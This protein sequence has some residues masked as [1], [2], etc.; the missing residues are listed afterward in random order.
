MNL[1]Y[2]VKAVSADK[3][4]NKINGGNSMLTDCMAIAN[5]ALK[6][7]YAIGIAIT[8]SGP[9]GYFN[10]W[11]K[12]DAVG[13]SYGPNIKGVVVA[14]DYWTAA[15]HE[16]GHTYNLYW[17]TPE[18][19]SQ[20]PLYGQMASGVCAASGNWRSGQ[21]FMGCAPYK[22]LDNTWVNSQGTYNPLFAKLTQT[23]TDPEIVVVS[24][25][26]HSGGSPD[27]PSF[28]TPFTWSKLQ[29]IPSEIVSGDY[30]LKFLDSAN[31]EIQGTEVMF[32]AQTRASISVGV[33][34]GKDRPEAGSGTIVS[35][36]A[37]F[38]FATV[39]PA[40]T[41]EVQVLDTT[42]PADQQVKGTIMESQIVDVGP[43]TVETEIG[44]SGLNGWFVSNVGVSLAATAAE[45]IGVKEIHYAL[46]GG[47][48]TVVQGNT[49][50]FTISTDGTHSLAYF[51]VD[52]NE[53]AENPQTKTIKIDKTVPT[54]T[55]SLPSTVLLKQVISAT[56]TATDSTSGVDPSSG[57]LPIDT[58]SVGTKTI[59]VTVWDK[60]GNAKTVTKTVNVE[61]NFIGF[62]DPINNDGTSI[63]K[64]KSTVPVK[65]Q[66]KDAQG[67]YVSTAVASISVAKLSNN[68]WG[69]DMEPVSTASSTQGTIF[70]YD[71]SSNQYIFNLSTKELSTG[72]WRIS[73]LLGDG[74]VKTVIISLR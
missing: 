59:S 53:I 36:D 73:S 64:L 14:Q 35:D 57:T 56:W 4:Q 10:K 32:D 50:S 38:C 61:Y 3:G 7:N 49:A 17:E 28:E 39:L 37:G 6:K 25:I 18:E 62:L 26:F 63:F 74:T 44:T 60:A 24:G 30:A 9:L 72:S 2:P 21:D 12:P 67:N 54:V 66:L 42:L 40:G 33:T 20:Y 70:R 43:A 22:T 34:L 8:T 13:V 58:N 5:Q 55:L 29:G 31:N 45:G 46:D 19:Y 51:A 71:A 27:T 52:N 41:A 68:V 1:A 69:E 11:G 47:T 65:F 23:L 16:V 15:A 48:S